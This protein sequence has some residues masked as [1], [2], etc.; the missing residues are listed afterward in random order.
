MVY[1][2]VYQNVKKRNSENAEES[3][4]LYVFLAPNPPQHRGVERGVERDLV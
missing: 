2:P 1:L 3:R 4:P